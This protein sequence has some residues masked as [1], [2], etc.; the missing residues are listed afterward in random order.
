MRYS[1][2]QVE[3]EYWVGHHVLADHVDEGRVGAN[4]GDGLVR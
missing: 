3:G 4:G 1:P 2:A